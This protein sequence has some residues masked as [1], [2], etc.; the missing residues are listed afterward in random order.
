[1]LEI[2]YSILIFSGTLIAIGAVIL[3][4]IA[5][6]VPQGDVH[7]L[8]NGERDVTTPPPDKQ[9]GRASCRERV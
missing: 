2:L 8:V 5:R 6:L 3:W 7:I 4:V 9:I 1:M